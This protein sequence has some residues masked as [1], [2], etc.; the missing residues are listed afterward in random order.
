MAKTKA[1]VQSIVKQDAGAEAWQSY[2]NEAFPWVESAKKIEQQEWIR[3]LQSEVKRG[4][5]AVTAAH[6]H[7]VQMKSRLRTKV[8]ERRADESVTDTRSITEKLPKA[9]PVGGRRAR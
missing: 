9:I 3:R 7:D 1:V 6:P 4:A 2:F 5:I 8:V